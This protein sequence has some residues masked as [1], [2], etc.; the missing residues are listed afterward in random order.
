M[1][2]E[3]NRWF[4]CTLHA[5]CKLVTFSPNEAIL[6]F[7]VVVHENKLQSIATIGV[8]MYF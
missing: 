1:A 6:V 3:I 2:S 5:L 7:N 8:K 4:N